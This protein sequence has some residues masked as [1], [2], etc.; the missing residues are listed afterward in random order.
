MQTE[1][2]SHTHTTGFMPQKQEKQKPLKK[3][4]NTEQ[5]VRLPLTELTNTHHID[6]FSMFDLESQSLENS[7]PASSASKAPT[8]CSLG[9]ASENYNRTKWKNCGTNARRDDAKNEQY[10]EELRCLYQA[11][12]DINEAL[13]DDDSPMG[14]EQV[15]NISQR[16]IESNSFSS[17]ATR[18]SE[19]EVQPGADTPMTIVNIG[20]IQGLTSKRPLRALVDSGSQ[21]TYI[22]KSALPMG[23]NVTMLE[24]AMSTRMLDQVTSIDS[25]VTLKDI[26][27]PELSA[28]THIVVPFEAYVAN[29][30]ATSFDVILG[31]DFSVALGINVLNDQRV[32]QWEENVTP[33][34]IPPTSTNRFRQLQQAYIDAFDDDSEDQYPRECHTAELLASKYDHCTMEDILKFAEDQKHL[35][36]NKRKGLQNLFMQFPTLFDNELRT[37]PGKKVH[38]ELKKDARPVYRRHYPVAH[39]HENLFKDELDQLVA[40]GVLKKVGASEWGLPSFA[41]PKKDNRIRFISDLRELN[42]VIKRKVYPL[43]RIADVL[44]RRNGYRYFTKL[45][46]SMMFYTFELDDESKKLC[47]ITTPFGHYEYQK[48]PMGCCQS[49]DVAQE[50]MESVLS[51][52]PEIEVYIDDVGIFTKTWEDHLRVLDVVLTRLQHNN[53]IINPQK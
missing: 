15:K 49:P 14:T 26:V 3:G 45:D 17:P 35:D 21:K 50:I 28:T 51:D 32:I 27:L 5:Q 30:Q 12:E 11:V 44:R 22:Y 18:I 33:F 23:T 48:L 24:T 13:F 16:V 38:L 4:K 43:P 29:A 42:K 2:G 40:I 37:Y 52:I 25:T 9:L 7:T 41:I 39:A 1:P 31:Q 10:E 6:C 46:V 47:T 8:N 20:E 19:F 53:F 36:P 34:R